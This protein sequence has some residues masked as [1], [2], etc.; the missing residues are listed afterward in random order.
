MVVP[1]ARHVLTVVEDLYNVLEQDSRPHN[2]K[3]ARVPYR[4]EAEAVLRFDDGKLGIAVKSHS[5]VP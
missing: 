5:A 1:V 4:K 2:P 3:Q